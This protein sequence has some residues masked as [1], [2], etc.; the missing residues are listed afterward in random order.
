M[1]LNRRAFPGFLLLAA[2][3]QLLLPV[4]PKAAPFGLQAQEPKPLTGKKWIDMDYGPWMSH[5]FQAG[6]PDGNIAYKGKWIRLPDS[7]SM[8]F[9]TDLLRWAGG[10]S[11]SELNWQNVIYDGSHG[12]HPAIIGE[13]VFGNP[14]KPGWSLS[15]DFEDPRELPY[16]PLPKKQADYKGLY[17]NGNR[18]ILSY[19]VGEVSILESPGNESY[20]GTNALARFIEV[21]PHESALQVQL[22]HDANRAVT[23]LDLQKL[24]PTKGGDSARIAVFGFAEEFKEIKEEKQSADVRDGLLAQW[25]FEEIEE[26]RL[27]NRAGKE[28]VGSAENVKLVEGPHGHAVL[29][30]GRADIRFGEKDQV[31]FGGSDFTITAFVKTTQNGTI[32]AKSA[33][34]GK[35]Q[36]NGKTFFVRDG[37]LG[38]D[39][40]WVGVVQSSRNVSDGRWHHVAMTHQAKDGQVQ[41]YIDGQADSRG[42]LKSVDDSEHVLRIGYTATDFMPPLQGSLDDVRI[43]NRVLEAKEVAALTG[44]ELQEQ[45][46]AIAIVGAA[47]ELLASDSQHDV[48]LNLPASNQ[49]QR[50]KILYWKGAQKDLPN[51]A[52]LVKSD[53]AD[54][55][56]HEMTH[57]GPANY[58]QTVETQGEISG[59]DKPYVIDN[60]TL[61]REN[62]WRSWMRIGGFDFFKDNSRA[63][64]CTWSGDVWTVSGIDDKLQNLVWRRI[65]TGMF[66]PL[67]LKIV[68]DRIYVGCRDEI[69]LLQ[70][71]NDDGETDYYQSFNHDHQVTEHFHEFA[72]D[73]QTDAEGNFYYA[74]SARHAL[75]SIVPQHGTIIK[76]SRDG[77]TSEIICNGFRAANGVGVGPHG[78]LITSDQEGHWTPANRINLVKKDGFYG[79]MYSFHRGERPADYEPPLV[80]LPK[81]VDRSPAAQFWCDSNRWGPFEN[82]LLSTSYGTG[83]LWHVMYET[84]DGIV[85]GGVVRMPVQFPTGIMRGRFQ[86][87]DGQLY[88]CGLVGW[89][90]DMPQDGGFFRVRY[91][92][93]PVHLTLEMHV[94]DQGIHLTFSEPLDRDAAEN[95]D[96]FNIEQW[97]YRWTKDYGSPHFS[98]ANPK[99][100]GQDEVELLEARLSA[101]GKTLFLEIEDI[102]PVMQMQIGY[103]LT[104]A[105]GTE[106]NDKIWLTINR[107][108]EE[109]NRRINGP[110]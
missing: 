38:F 40:G 12:T 97:N 72:M 27:R 91:T 93:R 107:L 24:Q 30:D 41:L 66:Q 44:M 52:A 80:W 29:L 83:K 33:V 18:V 75:D 13:Q 98:V 36:P 73:L 106:M 4:L 46:T 64:V 70:D 99:K 77:A 19:S 110:R 84:V 1:N 35:W 54:F 88:L 109:L 59:D 53:S 3:A 79:N 28:F 104:A 78:E 62:P 37:K 26:G 15:D 101:D 42:K 95:I 43:Y 57:G 7:Q 14:P 92:G 11:T 55:N 90:S 60:I 25:D 103:T 61:P 50:V 45:I 108:G 100:L 89:S 65:A 69:T 85:Q 8:L 58:R 74:K 9:D 20:E 76:V 34:K 67:G 81:N 71:L 31:N 16:G 47:S 96:N 49:I 10:W 32:V 51:F 23:L 87:R 68:D 63:A 94:T 102:Q 17:R 6:E 39:V 22:A 5:S 82:H 21:Q 48:R 105:D 2:C 86:P 56:L